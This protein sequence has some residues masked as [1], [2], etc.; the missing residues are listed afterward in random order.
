[1]SGY[2]TVTVTSEESSLALAGSDAACKTYQ[3]YGTQLTTT[4]RSRECQ[5]HDGGQRDV[6]AHVCR[7]DADHCLEAAGCDSDATVL[8][9]RDGDREGDRACPC[10]GVTVMP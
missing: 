4:G 9:R 8:E 3:Y 7:R 2:A 6:S 5:R 10:Q 1:V